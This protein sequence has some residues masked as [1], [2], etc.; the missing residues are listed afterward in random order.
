MPTQQ[1][2]LRTSDPR[3]AEQRCVTDSFY[4]GDV[5]VL[6]MHVHACSG[7]GTPLPPY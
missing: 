2:P 1:D 6:C 7:V 3:A 4:A 5:F